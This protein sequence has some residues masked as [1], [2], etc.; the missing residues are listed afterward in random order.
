MGGIG[1]VDFRTDPHA[2]SRGASTR[3]SVTAWSS[4]AVQQTLR[5]GR[6]AFVYFTADWCITCKLN[7]SRV[8]EDPRVQQAFTRL[9]IPVFRADWTR[10]DET[11]RGT[12]ATLGKA[13]VPAYVLY[14]PQDPDRPRVLPELLSVKGLLESLEQA[15]PPA[16]ARVRRNP[17]LATPGIIE[18]RS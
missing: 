10:R 18:A 2:P 9:D 13:G 17:P 12:L 1:V 11:I 16:Q 6:P 7:E 3:P 4:A 8:L 14:Q 5:A 15:R